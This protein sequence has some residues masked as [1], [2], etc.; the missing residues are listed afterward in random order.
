M[1]ARRPELGR[2]LRVAAVVAVGCAAALAAWLAVGRGSETDAPSSASSI[3][4]S[5]RDL[6][7]LAAARTVYWAGPMRGYRY[8]LT[9]TARGAIYVRY[10]PT[11]VPAGDPRP[12]F[13]TVGTYRRPNA[14]RGLEVEAR[15]RGTVVFHPAPRQIALFRKDRPT[16]VYFA[17]LGSGEQI[18]VYDPSPSRARRLV[19]TGRVRP[20]RPD[21]ERAETPR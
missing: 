1:S 14:Y 10:L 6:R 20:I 12:D 8:E 13:L 4:V 3:L 15:K 9:R 18:E 5:R 16:S 19:A 7:S 21:T 11:G 2:R 17:F